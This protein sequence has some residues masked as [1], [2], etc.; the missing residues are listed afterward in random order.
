[1]ATYITGDKHGDFRGL[2]RWAK[3]NELAEDDTII[4]LGD[5]GINYYK[6]YS[7][8][9][10][11]VMA[12]LLDMRPTLFCIHGNHE[13]RPENVVDPRS[14]DSSCLYE[15][16][17]NEKYGGYVWVDDAY[18]NIVFAD[19]WGRYFIDGH[20]CLVIG[21][22]YSVDKHWRLKSGCKWFESE[23]LDRDDR[24]TLMGE[25]LY[26]M[27]EYD[28]VLTHTCPY[29]YQPREWFL[30]CIDQSTVDNTTEIFLDEVEERIGYKRWYCGHFHGEKR[31]DDV[32]FLFN[33]V[34][35]FME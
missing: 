19:M 12:P 15:M 8:H 25:I 3:R 22:A 31:V 18:P 10:T 30:D 16:T 21:G 29:K 9:W 4:I 27:D 28:A 1:M 32:R 13:E 2:A 11:D 34:E 24:E 23:Q 26:G 33:S 5:S 20:V 14:A 6:P 35:R 17:Y 7:D